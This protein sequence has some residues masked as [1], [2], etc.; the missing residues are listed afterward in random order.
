MSISV[1]GVTKG[2][3]L[4]LG[5]GAVIGVALLF[6]GAGWVYKEFKR[7][8][9]EKAKKRGRLKSTIKRLEN[10]EL[11]SWSEENGEVRLTLTERG[12]KKVLQYKIEDM[13]VNIPDK[14]DGFWRVIVFDIPEDQ[15]TARDIFRDKLKDMGLQQLQKSVFLCRYDCKDQIDF[16]RHNLEISP[17]VHYIVAKEISNLELK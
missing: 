16:L 4:A 11:I 1:N 15:K 8:Q 5:A 10:Q 17:H 6:P 7:E 12:K 9:W 13:K 14:W 2:L 3:L